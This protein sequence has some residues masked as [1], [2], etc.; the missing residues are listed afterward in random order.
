M[1]VLEPIAKT[2]FFSGRERRNKLPAIAGS[3]VGS[4]NIMER[5]DFMEIPSR[6]L[7]DRHVRVGKFTKW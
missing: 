7:R 3:Y 6:T 4:V 2:S 5:N 1:L